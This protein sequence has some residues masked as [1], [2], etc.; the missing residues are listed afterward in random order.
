MELVIE[1]S[2]TNLNYVIKVPGINTPA[3]LVRLEDS[4]NGFDY[5]ENMDFL[6]NRSGNRDTGNNG[7]PL[8]CE[9]T[10][11]LYYHGS[12]HR[13]ATIIGERV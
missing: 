1:V 5:K 12:D 3:L 13:V 10:G 2:G 11:S 9:L 8:L 4:G 7:I 6:I